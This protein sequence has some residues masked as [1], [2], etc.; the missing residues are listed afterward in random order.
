MF[1][2]FLSWWYIEGWLA[3]AESLPKRA[4]SLNAAFSTAT[5]ARTLFQPWRRI[6]TYPGASL[7]D[8]MHALADNLFS[9]VVGFFVRI[10]VLMAAALAL[11]LVT[12]ATLV[13]TLAW[14]LLP[15]GVIVFII[16]AII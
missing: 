9:R 3:V 8:K 7:A 16:M 6:I 5:L 14:P 10:F 13:E 1:V 12:L 4:A 15:L 11:A 2:A